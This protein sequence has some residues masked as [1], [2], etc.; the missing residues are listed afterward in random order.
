MNQTTRFNWKIKKFSKVASRDIARNYLDSGVSN[1]QSTSIKVRL[2]FYP[3]DELHGT[4]YCSIWL[5]P[6]DLGGAKSIE[7]FLDCHVE[8]KKGMQIG[9]VKSGEYSIHVLNKYLQI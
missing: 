5:Y 8:N 2:R 1:L 9:I 4:D 6:I 3:I 7:V